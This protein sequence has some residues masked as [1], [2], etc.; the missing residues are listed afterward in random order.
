M[1]DGAPLLKKFLAGGTSGA[2]GAGLANPADLVK[3]TAL[4]LSLPTSTA[5]LARFS[6]HHPARSLVFEISVSF[7]IVLTLTCL[8]YFATS[9]SLPI[10]IQSHP[11]IPSL[12]A[13]C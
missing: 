3:V 5:L 4:S 6:I 1:R 2:I 13:L 7:S 11:C 10:K 12:D 8:H 9:Y